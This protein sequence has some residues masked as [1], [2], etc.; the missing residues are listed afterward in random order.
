MTAT[1]P[2]AAKRRTTAA[3]AQAAAKAPKRTVTDYHTAD[4]ICDAAEDADRDDLVVALAHGNADAAAVLA[5]LDDEQLQRTQDMQAAQQAYIQLCEDISYPVDQ[6]GRVH[7]L[8]GLATRNQDLEG[9]NS[10]LMAIFWTMT[11]LGYR[12]VGPQFIKKRY[13]PPS[14]LGGVYK[15][16]HTWVD[17]R[18]PDDAAQELK[19]QHSSDDRDLPPD[20]RAAA[21]RR[22]GQVPTVTAEW[23]VKA[24][25]IIKPGPRPKGW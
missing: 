8:Q 21:A 20:L 12:R 18:A 4:A 9:A 1:K 7:D 5:G 6:A 14:M 19:P 23:K 13:Y 15:D 3:A 10:T 17:M 16:V 2:R 11:L 22:D 24:E 25:P